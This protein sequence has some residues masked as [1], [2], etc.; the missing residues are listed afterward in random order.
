L[1]RLFSLLKGRRRALG[2]LLVPL[3]LSSFSGLVWP[4]AMGLAMD[5]MKLSE[6]ATFAVDWRRLAV[7]FAIGTVAVLAGQ[8]AALWMAY[9]TVSLSN[10]TVRDMRGMLFGHVQSLPVAKFDSMKRGEFMSRLTNDIDMVANTLGP[11]ILEFAGSVF[12]LVM[13][14]GYMLYISPAMTLAACATL[15]LTIL[16]ARAVAGVSRRLFRE[17]QKTLGE[18]NGLTEEMISQQS[19]VRAFN[20]EE[21]V[22]ARFAAVSETLRGIGVKAETLGGFMWPMMGAINNLGFLLVATIGGWLALR[23]EITVG[24][25]ITFIA[26]ARQF[27]RPVSMLAN[28]F[29]QIQS[30]IAGAERVFAMLDMDPETDTGKRV[31]RRD[32]IRGAIEFDR[33][34]F[35]YEPGRPVLDNFTLR[36]PPGAKIALVGET[37]SGKTTVINLLSRFYEPDSGRILVDGADVREFTKASLRSCMAVVLQDTRLFGGTIA[38]NIAFGRPGATREEVVAAA[39][40]ANAD[41]FIDRLPEGYETNIAQN[42][43][44]LSQG[45]RQL[46]AIA[47]AALSDPAI[48]ILDEATSNVDTRTE[49]HIQQ[50]MQRLMRDRTSVI[51]AH[52][53]STIRDADTILV[54]RDGRISESGTHAELMALDGIYAGYN[55]RVPVG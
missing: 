43:T 18:L 6:D 39:R 40:L 1:A 32:A 33:V 5:T 15:P 30:S 8:A 38:Q 11:G 41:L 51:I 36:V 4:R 27:G 22:G 48:L 24:V 42:E 17:R 25:I 52:R 23:G 13:T 34:C 45:Q 20:R 16:A 21:A 26:Y 46:L 54:M 19:A 29:T 7:V 31:A 2:I 44:L 14:L 53:V 3:V 35:A 37:G 28:Q 47:R 49:L 10:K 12:G 9:G 50:A 55:K